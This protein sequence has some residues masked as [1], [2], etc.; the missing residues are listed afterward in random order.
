MNY[1]VYLTALPSL[2]HTICARPTYPPDPDTKFVPKAII[3]QQDA[4]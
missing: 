4:T 3:F 1:K 2:G